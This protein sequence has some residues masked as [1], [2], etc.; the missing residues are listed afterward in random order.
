MGRKSNMYLQTVIDDLFNH[1]DVKPT[2]GHYKDGTRAKSISIGQ[3]FEKYRIDAGQSVIHNYRKTAIKTG[4]QEMLWIYQDQTS[5]LLSAH[6]RGIKWWDNWKM[7]SPYDPHIGNAYGETVADYE[8]L[9][10][11]LQGMINDPLS[12]RHILSLWQKDHIDYQ[13][14]HGG[15]VPCAYE[16]LWSI[17]QAHEVDLTLIQRSS[18]Y[19]TANAINKSQYVAFGLMVCG[20]LTYH[21]GKKHSLKNFAHFV[22]DLHIYDRHVD[23]LKEIK[24]NI[25][26][27]NHYYSEQLIELP[28]DK[29]FYDYTIDDFVIKRVETPKIKSELE[30]VI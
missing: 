6:K 3:H 29:D 26:I 12:R 8:L 5:C 25:K 21:T 10:S 27:D 17:N 4:I 20:H 1:G 7:D 30:I 9:G 16:T 13:L 14:D 24:G 28:V 19:I 2:R 18:D 15:L 22:Q 11:L 23:A